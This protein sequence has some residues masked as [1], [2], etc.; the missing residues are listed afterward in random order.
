LA[1]GGDMAR[2]VVIKKMKKKK[3][4]KEKEKKKK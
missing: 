2:K 4:E 1:D 3:R